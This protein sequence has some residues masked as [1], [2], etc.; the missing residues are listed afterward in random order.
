MDQ[1]IY[2]LFLKIIGKVEKQDLEILKLNEECIRE[3]PWTIDSISEIVTSEKL[4]RDSFEMVELE[5]ISNISRSII[6]SSDYQP[7]INKQNMKELV[8]H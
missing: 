7:V 2:K 3:W 4:I 6:N 8:N 1:H 5:E